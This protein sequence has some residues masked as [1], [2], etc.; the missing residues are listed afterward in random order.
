MLTEQKLDKLANNVVDRF[1]NEKIALTD[2]V[3]TAANDENLNPE[4]VKR[5]VESVNNLTFLRKFGSM[6]GPERMVEFEPADSNGA[7]QR[8]ID[9]AGDLMTAE[10]AADDLNKQANDLTADLPMTRPDA[11]V[12]EKTAEAVQELREPRITRTGTILKLRKT[13]E[14]L[15]EQRHQERMKLSDNFQ[16]LTTIFTRPGCPSFETFEKDAFYTWGDDAG[17]I[18][19][20]LRSCHQRPSA[21]YNHTQMTKT[22]RVVDTRTPEMRHLRAVIDANQTIQQIVDGQKKIAEYLGKLEG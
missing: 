10:P 8:M 17:V 4:Q 9:A 19:Q 2:G 12:L 21:E 22:A 5:L 7:L 16:T 3:V 13:A 1:L 20:M 15:E 11:P 18:L 14:Y 6:A